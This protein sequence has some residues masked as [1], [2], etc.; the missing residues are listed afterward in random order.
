MGNI[1]E[2]IKAQGMDTREATVRPKA[3][4]RTTWRLLI[5]ASSS[6]NA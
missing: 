5:R 3:S 4:E 2:D 6:A 1:M